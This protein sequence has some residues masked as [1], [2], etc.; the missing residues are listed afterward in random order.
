[1]VTYC[2]GDV[3]KKRAY[4]KKMIGD[5]IVNVDNDEITNVFFKKGK[6]YFESVGGLPFK[7]FTVLE[8][9]RYRRAL[10]DDEIM[11]VGTLKKLLKEYKVNK[12]LNCKIKRLST[13]EYRTVCL[14][15]KLNSN[16]DFVCLNFDGLKETYFN[17]LKLNKLL[18][19]LKH[20]FNVYLATTDKKLIP[21]EGLVKV[22]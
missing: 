17:R 5:S 2:I 18:K 4:F 20:K 13:I 11:A 15:A 16:A 8:F 21:K 6:P 7:N 14:I 19:I 12:K 22:F 1:M 9:V 10:I 3:F